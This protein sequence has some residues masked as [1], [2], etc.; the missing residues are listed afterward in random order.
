[1]FKLCIFLIFCLSATSFSEEKRFRSYLD[2]AEYFKDHKQYLKSA[3]AYR[4]LLRI[5]PKNLYYLT[6]I[7]KMYKLAGDNERAVSYYLRLLHFYPEDTSAEFE[8]GEI[9]YK[10]EMYQRALPLLE[11]VC[12][13]DIENYR[14]ALY[15]ARIFTHTGETDKAKYYLDRLYKLD[16]TAPATWHAGKN[17]YLSQG[18]FKDA[19][20]Y[21]FDTYQTVGQEELNYLVLGL[22]PYIYPSLNLDSS[23]TEEREKDLI[24]KMVTTEINTWN[25][26]LDLTIPLPPHF[27]VIN[28]FTFGD[29]RQVNLQLGKN[30]YFV[31]VYNYLVGLEVINEPNFLM[32][33][34][35]NQKWGAD[36]PF[37]FFPYK[38][39]L[40]WEPAISF[41][42][43]NP[44]H[45]ASIS[46]YKDSYL[47]RHFGNNFRTL[48]IKRK[49]VE[50][51][52][53]FRDSNSLSSIG[54]MGNTGTYTS[55]KNNFRS[56]I[57]LWARYDVNPNPFHM[58]FEYRYEFSTFRRIDR[59]YS[60]YRAGYQHLGKVSLIRNWKRRGFLDCNYTIF[61][62]KSVS[63]KKLETP[64]IL[65]L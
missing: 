45:L 49:L 38:H 31:D 40:L 50:A 47:S 54:F 19:Y 28:R 6:M 26:S 55:V 30:N 44:N 59:D 33:I 13:K 14:A 25:H 17:F 10:A 48:F 12:E 2:E 7:S 37:T 57:S 51:Y 5:D 9:Y 21:L 3:E 15:L 4:H 42:Y 29:Q 41:R 18:R 43:S 32:K 34:Y 65:R 62:E 1:M 11:D 27:R 58:V 23:Y 8:L 35:S 56:L 63:D 16:R 64:G 53:E 52:Y 46:A 36:K 39:Q 61:W 60:S 24:T 20:K 22:R